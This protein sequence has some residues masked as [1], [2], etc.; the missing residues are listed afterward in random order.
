MAADWFSGMMVE[1]RCWA[2]SGVL[3]VL[4]PVPLL[5]T[6]TYQKAST[7][8][9]LTGAAA[10]TAILL[11]SAAWLCTT[12]PLRARLPGIVGSAGILLLLADKLRQSPAAALLI[13][14]V[15]TVGTFFLWRRDFTVAAKP[16]TSWPATRARAAS[17]TFVA[18]WLVVSLAGLVEAQSSAVLWLYP[19]LAVLAVLL[20]LWLHRAWAVHRTR[21][22]LIMAALAVCTGG[23][24]LVWGQWWLGLYPALGF[25]IATSIILPWETG[26]ESRMQSLEWW[27]PILGHPER[28]LVATFLG[29]CLLGTLTLALPVSSSTGVGIGTIDALFTAVSAV[30]VTGLIVLDTPVDFSRTGQIFI[31][32]LIQLGGLG[33]MTFSTA[34]LQ[35]LGRRLSLRHEGAV[36]R[37]VSIQDRSL[38]FTTARTILKFTLIAEFVGGALLFIGFKMAGDSIAMAAWRACFTAISAFCNA[39]FALQ[40]SSLIDYQQDAFILH[41]V[42]LLI[43]IGGLSPAVVLSLPALRGRPR[44]PLGAQTKIVLATSGFLLASGF[45]WVLGLEWSEALAEL[46]LWDRIHNAW[47]Q[48]VTLRTAGFNSIELNELRPATISLMV[49]Y[50]FIGGSPGGTAGGIKT[51]T[52][53]LLVLSVLAAGQG[54]SQVRVFGRSV[55]HSSLYKATA[56]TTVGAVSVLLTLFAIQI[57]QLIPPQIALFEVTSA[58]GTVGLSLGGTTLLDGVGK[59]IIALAMFAGRVGPL[60]L[61]L[62]LSHK[63]RQT[64]WRFPD[65]EID[66]G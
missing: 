9:W 12:Q 56:I 49:V 28:L 48:S 25:A 7:S 32:I 42:A 63:T 60:T 64:V 16:E 36:A 17:V 65:E 5:I 53:A 21:A 34:A 40:S 1:R 37:L 29:L 41:I 14:S 50:M 61:F 19:S 44:K 62:F 4:A 26:R 24:F 18:L 58:L 51:T 8:V 22:M 54:R 10:A 47:F 38:L 46:S 3:A 57:T 13:L 66:V 11:L 35:L 55:P 33:I 39:G 20:L 31:L 27:D 59:V 23:L 15:S 52:F 43:I 6:D 30:C 45:F 2:A